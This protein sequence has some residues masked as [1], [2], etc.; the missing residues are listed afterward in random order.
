[1]IRLRDNRR[2]LE[3]EITIGRNPD[4]APDFFKVSELPYEKALNAYVVEDAEYC[5]EQVMDFVN[6][7][8]K[9]ANL[10]PMNEYVFFDSELYYNRTEF[11]RDI[12]M[13]HRRYCIKPEDERIADW[14]KIENSSADYY[15]IENFKDRAIDDF[16]EGYNQLELDDN[17]IW[18]EVSR[19]IMFGE[20]Y[21]IKRRAY[22][23]EGTFPN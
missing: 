2:T 3:I 10:E 22:N 7:T 1:M 12:E 6:R 19:S 8:G 5:L 13:P 9:F 16:E 14:S 15:E 23:V 21:S 11:P 4:C 18:W 17:G 20:W